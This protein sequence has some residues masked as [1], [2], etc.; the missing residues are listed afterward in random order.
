[1]IETEDGPRWVCGDDRWDDWGGRKGAAGA[2]GGRR[3][4]LERGGVL[5]PGVLRPTTT[6]LRLEDIARDGIDATVMYG[7]IVPLLIKDPDLRGGLLSRVQRVARRV[8]R[9]GA[10]AADRRGPDP[11]RRAEDGRRRGPPPEDFRLRTGMFLA[12][13][14]E[15]VVGRGVGAAVDGRGGDTA[16]RLAFTSVASSAPWCR[17][18]PS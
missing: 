1:M 8:L 17:A 2:R 13:N 11:H 14:V 16:V 3:S 15:R 6:A 5:E 10:R 18:V 7:P 4:A 9:D 12:A